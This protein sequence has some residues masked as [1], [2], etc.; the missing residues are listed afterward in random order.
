LHMWGTSHTIIRYWDFAFDRAEGWY[1]NL[2]APWR[3][4]RIGIDTQDFVLDITV[5][6]DLSSW[7]WKDEDELAWSV[8]AGLYSAEDAAAIRAEGDRS[9]AALKARA[10][11]FCADWSEW[12]PN[13]AWAIPTLPA[14][15][16]DPSL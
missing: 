4:T 8:D 16:A 7:S 6:A 11:P 15:W 3:R 9:V 5:A 12:R 1:V 10:W 2:E 13:P 14:D